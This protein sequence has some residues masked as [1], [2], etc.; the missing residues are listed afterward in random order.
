MIANRSCPTS[1]VIPEL[2]YANPGQAAE[3]LCFA[4]GFTVR[5]R[6][7]N[8]RI[9][10][11]V[12]E[13]LNVGDGAVVAVEKGDRPSFASTMV[14]V[15]DADAHYQRSLSRGA[16]ILSP[17]TTYPYGERQYSVEDPEGH[18]WH[19]TQSVADVDPADWGG[20]TGKL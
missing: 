2:P 3:W 1:T 12:G 9:Q 17:P 4:F 19:F 15:E 10:L 7:G 11:N 14:R 13:G 20:E 5:I 18:R 8:H 6:I 16:R